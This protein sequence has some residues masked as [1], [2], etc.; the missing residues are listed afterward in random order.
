LAHT[1]SPEI[2]ALSA[3]LEAAE[4]D[5]ARAQSAHAPTLDAVAQ[6][7]DSGNENVTRLN[8][9]FENKAIGF[10]LSVPLYQGGAVNSQVR[11]AV[12]EK[13]RV[14]ES[15]ESLR[16][17]LNLRVHKE[18]RGVT[19]GLLR[20][21]ALEQALRSATQLL[22]ST[23]KSQRAG[24]RTMLDVLNAEQQLVNVNRDLI[25]ARYVYLMS[26]LRLSSLAGVDA[27][28]SVSEINRAF[29]P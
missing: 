4:K 6:W 2:K 8:S 28:T 11:Q 15:L 10:Q 29:N 3:R 14:A 21:Q 7:S 17:D 23:Q 22:D 20:I 18:Y 24:V 16:R 1:N 13:T 25:Q 19:E 27:V 9:R 5:I 12:A 26:R